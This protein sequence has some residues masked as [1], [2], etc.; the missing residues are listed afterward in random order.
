[1]KIYKKNIVLIGMPGCGKS[2][3]GKKLSL[4]LGLDFC[5]L[6]VCI[7]KDQNKTIKEIFKSG[8]SYFRD[9]EQRIVKDVSKK[10]GLVIATGGGVVLRKC[11]IIELKK[12]GVIVF[13]NREV[14][15]IICD[16]NIKNRPLLKDGKDK[17][18]ELYKK[19]YKLYTEYCDF[20]VDNCGSLEDAVDKIIKVLRGGVNE[21]T[22]Y[23]W[24]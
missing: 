10:E 1:M 14:K 15:D 12:N 9:V 17:L 5:D 22:Y 7:E 18:Y 13:I 6:D 16:I 23:Q 2:T 19:R 20:K 4:K 11:N 24:T 3:I 21:D 8:E